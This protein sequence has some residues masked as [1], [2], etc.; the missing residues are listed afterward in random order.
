[1]S[2]ILYASRQSGV[3]L[4]GLVLFSVALAAGG[5]RV[6]VL[7]RWTWIA[8][9]ISVALAIPL[10]A[11]RLT[12]KL[13]VLYAFL[14]SVDLLTII[15]GIP[16]WLTWVLLSVAVVFFT[17]T[18]TIAALA[19]LGHRRSIEEHRAPNT[20][21]LRTAA[22]QQSSFATVAAAAEAQSR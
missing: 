7:P 15:V 5:F 11:R 9:L 1:M 20:R 14:L 2:A 12:R 22:Q 8:G 3:A 6:A 13:G 17:I 16:W 21:L 19:I 4:A 10:D 18:G